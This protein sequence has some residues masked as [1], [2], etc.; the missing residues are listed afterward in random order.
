MSLVHRPWRLL[1][2]CSFGLTLAALMGPS[3]WA[4]PKYAIRDLGTLP[5]TTSSAATAI[6][7]QG[8]VVGVSYNAEDGRFRYGRDGS[9]EAPRFQSEGGGRSFLYQGGSM[10]PATSLG[11]IAMDINDRGQVVGGE[12]R[13]SINESGRYVGA[14]LSSIGSYSDATTG[15][16]PTHMSMAYGINDQGTVVG[17]QVVDN[18]F[19]GYSVFP[20]VLRDGKLTYLYRSPDPSSRAGSFDGRAV[21]V[22]NKDQALVNV[23]TDATGLRSSYLYDINAKSR[24]DLTALPGGA[25]KFGV[26]L[27][28]FGQVV[29]NGFLYDGS[30]IRMLTDLLGTPGGWSSLNA[31]DVNDSG[32][33]VGQGTIDGQQ[34]AFLMTPEGASVPEPATVLIW[35]AMGSVAARKLLR[36]SRPGGSTAA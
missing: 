17:G 26:A 23:V 21:D 11:G 14:T 16:S 1:L 6:N 18:P 20:S 8:Q 13:T 15:S 25:G 19:T 9:V 35:A 7:D 31:T 3:A 28:D 33:I 34:H 24:V 36:R 22:N 30:T 4:S 5:G 12:Y 32:W 27:N 29:G 10:G 2:A